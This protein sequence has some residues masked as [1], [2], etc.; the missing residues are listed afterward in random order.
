MKNVESNKLVTKIKME[1]KIIVLFDK[2]NLSVCSL[3]EICV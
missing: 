3:Y 1:L 2:C